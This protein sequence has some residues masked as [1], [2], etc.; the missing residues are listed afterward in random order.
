MTMKDKPQ[1]PF[2]ISSEVDRL[3]KQHTWI[4]H[5][6]K[7]KIVFAPVPLDKE[8]L[9][10]LDVGCADGILLR[11]I[12]KQVPSSAQLV[13]VDIEDSF[14]P[15]S[16]SGI[17]YE[18]Y[19]LCE[20]PNEGLTE[21]FDLTHMR[22]VMAAA[23]RVGYQKAVENLVATL[24]PGGW[25]QVH[26]LD[27]SL[28]GRSDAGPAWKDVNTVFG[29]MFDAMGM[30]SDFVSKLPEAFK[31]AGLVNV[32]S[33]TILLPTGK[34]LNDEELAEKSRQAFVMTIPNIIQGAKMFKADIP[35]STYENLPER[36]EKEVKEQGAVFRTKII[37]GQKPA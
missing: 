14:F 22:Y 9:K 7:N 27:F 24:A 15:V 33:E 26:E 10:I 25:L 4:N 16:D 36:F 23:G 35:E 19:D 31:T 18:V 37:I 2:T 34:L 11:D 30:G 12:Q 8:G 28:D 6:L 32:S 21:V 20:S 17:K 3:Q 5:V 29:G 13:G 1:Y